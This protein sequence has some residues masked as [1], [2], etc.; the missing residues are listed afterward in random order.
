MNSE[1]LSPR[2]KEKYLEIQLKLP[3]TIHKFVSGISWDLGEWVTLSIINGLCKF[4][5]VCL[6]VLSFVFLGLH[7]R[8]L[9]APMPRVYSELLLPAY[10]RATT[11]PD[12]S[13]IC[14]LH[15]SSQQ[16][17]DP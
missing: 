1:T 7:P 4:L 5:F 8:H 12:P 11:M 17:R 10:A 16:G 14:D 2:G 6:F 15:H 9:E 13:R 3:K